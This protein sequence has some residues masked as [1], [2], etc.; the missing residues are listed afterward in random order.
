MSKDF[1]PSRDADLLAWAQANSAKL[2]ASPTTFFVTAPIASAYAA[3][4]ASYAA[5]F[6]AARADNAGKTDRVVLREARRAL[7]ANARSWVRLVQGQPGMTMEKRSELQ[8][9]LRDNPGSPVNPPSEPPVVQVVKAIGRS[10]VVTTRAAGSSR[11]SKPAGAQ[12]STLFMYVGA[13]P[14]GDVDDWTCL[15]QSTRTTFDVQ[16]PAS[17]PA[18][19]QVWFSA[20]W[21]SPRGQYTEMSNPISA[22]VAGG[23]AASGQGVDTAGEESD[24]SML[25]AA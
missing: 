15:G 9:N 13:V 14:S 2:T 18:G 25:K 1:I 8:I 20:V 16:L 5:A 21:Y 7:V 10:M 24:A 22:Y 23:I 3:L 19:A 4:V 6:A 17:V 11:R 12:G